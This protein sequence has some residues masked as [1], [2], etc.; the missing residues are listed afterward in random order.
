[1]P[2]I[3][4]DFGFTVE[5]PGGPETDLADMNVRILRID[6]ELIVGA[7]RMSRTEAATEQIRTDMEEMREDMNENTKLTKDVLSG[8]A[9]VVEFFTAMKG[10]FKVLNWMGNLAKPVAAIVGLGTAIFVAY[11]AWSASK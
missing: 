4:D 6:S 1:M 3:T 11:G 9:D 7:A 8:L 2:F 10:A 5:V